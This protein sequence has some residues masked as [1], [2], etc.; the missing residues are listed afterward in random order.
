MLYN[1]HEKNG[2]ITNA[3]SHYQAR[4]ANLYI[5]PGSA[6]SVTRIQEA[7]GRTHAGGA[8]RHLPCKGDWTPKDLCLSHVSWDYTPIC[9][10]TLKMGPTCVF[11]F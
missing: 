2:Q 9:M 6:N 1:L 8:H 7:D 3:I 11:R 10:W 4:C 5:A